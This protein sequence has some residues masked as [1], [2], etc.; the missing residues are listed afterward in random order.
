MGQSSLGSSLLGKALGPLVSVSLCL[1]L[2]VTQSSY[3]HQTVPF[4]SLL[5][6]WRGGGNRGKGSLFRNCIEMERQYDT[7]AHVKGAHS[8]RLQ[9]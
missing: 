1:S 5:G 8:S 7:S 6:A 3:E 4:A 2:S 9:H